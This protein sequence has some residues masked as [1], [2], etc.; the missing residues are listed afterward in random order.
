MSLFLVAVLATALG[1]WLRRWWLLML[2]I[3]AATGAALLL[4]MPGTRVDADNPLP[5]L[6]V[7]IELF[8][9]VGVTAGKRLTR[10]T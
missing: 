4:A 8:L 3:A 10:P 1:T 9:A 2:P 6:L 5:F 7:L